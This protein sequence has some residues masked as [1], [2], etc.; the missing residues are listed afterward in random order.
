MSWT[1]TLAALGEE[2]QPAAL[3]LLITGHASRE[4][5]AGGVSECDSK[6]TEVTGGTEGEG[7]SPL[8]TEGEKPSSGPDVSTAQ[9]G[10]PAG[11]RPAAWLM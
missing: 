4:E 1:D 6:H 9:R 3:S 10:D 11:A 2:A 8:R 7:R 5:E